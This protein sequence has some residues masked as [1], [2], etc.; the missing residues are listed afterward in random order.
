M[1]ADP[2]PPSS[3]P[4]RR[5]L[6][7]VR[8]QYFLEIVSGSKA[9]EVR[10]ATPRWRAYAARPP[11]VGVFLCGRQVHRRAIVAVRIVGSATEALGRLPSPQG[12]ADLGD[13][14]VVVFDLGDPIP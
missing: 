10:R 13:G 9:V 5:V 1:A 4:P 6:F 8:R 7:T 3:R 11:A 12:A 2:E 14:P